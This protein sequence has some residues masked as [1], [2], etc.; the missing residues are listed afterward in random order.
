MRFAVKAS[1]S[2]DL[3]REK[4]KKKKGGAIRQM[5]KLSSGRT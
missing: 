3:E 4:K 2:N 1:R 5:F